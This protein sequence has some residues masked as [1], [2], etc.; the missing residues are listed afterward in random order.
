MSNSVSGSFHFEATRIPWEKRG[1]ERGELRFRRRRTG[2]RGFL[3]HF[4]GVVAEALWGL[5]EVVGKGCLLPTLS[6]TQPG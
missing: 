1:C 4:G 5:C 2:C 6:V 3:Y